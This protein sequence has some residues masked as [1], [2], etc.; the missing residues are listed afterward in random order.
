LKDASNEESIL[1][2]LN[3]SFKEN[4]ENSTLIPKAKTESP[5]AF[6]YF[7]QQAYLA[8]PIYQA[9]IKVN[10]S[11]QGKIVSIYSNLVTP[12][13]LSAPINFPS[14]EIDALSNNWI[15]ENKDIKQTSTSYC[16]VATSSSLLPAVKITY[17]D[18]NEIAHEVIIDQ[19]QNTQSRI[20]SV[21]FA[22]DSMVTGKVYNP[23]P[24]TTATVSYGGAYQDFDD[25]DVVVLNN[26]RQT[27]TFKT[28]FDGST[29]SLKNQY[30]ELRDNNG[31]GILPVTS[32]TPI[33]DFTRHQSGFED[34]N[35]FY[36]ISLHSNYIRTLGFNASS[37]LVY[38]DPHAGP[39]DNS[40][41]TE[42]NTIYFGTGGV[43]D[44]EDADVLIHEYTH[45]VSYTAS[46]G[47]NI[48]QD[49][50]SMDE[51]TCDYFAASYSKAISTYN[52]T[53][54]FNWDGNMP[55]WPGRVVNT[56]KHYPENSTTNIY[57]DASMWSS[58]LMQIHG[59]LGRATTD[60][61]VLQTMYLFAPNMSYPQVARALLT[62]DTLITG[63]RNFCVLYKYLYQRGYIPLVA[64]PCGINS[65]DNIRTI[66]LQLLQTPNGFVLESEQNDIQI[67]GY[68]IIDAIG[69]NIYKD[70]TSHFDKKQNYSQ[71]LYF[72]QVETNLG[73]KTFKVIF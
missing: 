42:P 27:K 69:N 44:A 49:R 54:L 10:I 7:F 18:K 35:T 9:D 48:G 5:A 28:H 37:Q 13:Q 15:M 39:Q 51:G 61:L 8:I 12:K 29:F 16:F 72:V 57:N 63:G 20:T 47:T 73:N 53:R 6:H 40:F 25:S 32:S 31:D 30:I 23:D 65:I 41:F 45:F 1:N 24:L 21:F 64:N 68:T 14:K 46:P 55:F 17:K 66:P 2:Y 62:A 59:E 19:T 60:S 33:F 3:T 67:K 58:T 50:T 22:Q 52:W 34:V 11:K 71:G 56:T 26:Q 70:N 36:H 43:D 38:P 4:I